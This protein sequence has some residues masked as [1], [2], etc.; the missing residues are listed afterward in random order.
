M[1]YMQE[2]YDDA[3]H[4]IQQHIASYQEHYMDELARILM[5]DDETYAK[6]FMEISDREGEMLDY[7]NEEQE[8][9]FLPLQEKIDK[10]LEATFLEFVVRIPQ[11]YTR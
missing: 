4:Y 6:W 3:R 11:E 2:M 1:T 7:L 10:E 8:D 9:E 5:I